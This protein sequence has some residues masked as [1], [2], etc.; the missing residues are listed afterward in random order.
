MLKLA[1]K[2]SDPL[3]DEELI[4][5]CLKEDRAAQNQLFNRFAPMM[6]GV[7][8]RYVQS[9]MEAED[10]MQDGFVKVFN[11]LRHF[12]KEA[13]LKTWITRIMVNTAITYLRS[14]KKFRLESDVADVQDHELVTFQ[15]HR[16]DTEKLMD[17]IRQLPDGYRVILNLFAIEGYSHKEIADQLGIAESTSRSQFTRARQLL[18]KNIQHLNRFDDHYAKRSI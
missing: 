8:H 5:A 17:C 9:R 4:A 11:N 6:L 14:A 1:F 7:C 3:N 13:S 18:E 2:K 16:M 10:V 15:L 12:R